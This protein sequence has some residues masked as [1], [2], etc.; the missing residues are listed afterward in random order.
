MIWDWEV[1]E[2]KEW[3]EKESEREGF[4]NLNWGTAVVVW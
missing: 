2:K 1:G 3:W 4:L